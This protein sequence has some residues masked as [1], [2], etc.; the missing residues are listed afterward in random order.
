MDTDFDLDL[1]MD[2]PQIEKLTWKLTWNATTKFKFGIRT[3]RL[4]NLFEFAF[5]IEY[6][7]PFQ[8]IQM[9]N[10]EADLEVDLKAAFTPNLEVDFD[11]E[12]KPG[13][14]VQTFKSTVKM[15]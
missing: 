10:W 5:Q 9:N 11:F 4:R 15:N 13:R 1:N 6:F 2:Q 3:S 14:Q 8:T 12:V 7:T